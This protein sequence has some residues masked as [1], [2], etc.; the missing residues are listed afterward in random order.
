MAIRAISNEKQTGSLKLVLQ[1]PFGLYRLIAI[2]LA[3]LFVGWAIAV[4]PTLSA[5]AI[6]GCCWAATSTGPS[7]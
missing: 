3:A 7:C 2:K 5:L 1:L 4:L 6:W